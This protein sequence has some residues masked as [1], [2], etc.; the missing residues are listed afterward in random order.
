MLNSL[1]AGVSGIKNEQNHLDVISNNI[2]NANTTGFKSS[3]ITFA[4]ALSLNMYSATQGLNNSAGRNGMQIGAGSKVSSIDINFKQGNLE[5]TG[6]VRDMAIKGKGFFVVSDGIQNFYTRSGAFQLDNQGYLLAQGG[7]HNVMGKLADSEGNLPSTTS[8]SLEKIQIPYGAKSPA[9]ATSTIDFFCNLNKNASKTEEWMI[10]APWLTDSNA[11][12]GETDLKDIDGFIISDG[13]VIQLSGTNHDGS[14]VSSSFTYTE[15]TNTVED[16][17]TAIETAYNN[18]VTAE[19]DAYGK[20]RI[21]NVQAGESDFSITLTGI[22]N[23]PSQVVSSD[24]QYFTNSTGVATA[25]ASLNS[26]LQVT[27]DYVDGDT[28]D[29]TLNGATNTF[30]FGESNNGTTVQDLIDFINNSDFGGSSFTASIDDQGTLTINNASNQSQ[31]YSIAEGTTNTGSGLAVTVAGAAPINTAFNNLLQV[32]VAYEDGDVINVNINTQTRAFTYG[33]DGTTLQDLVNF[34]NSNTF[35]GET[36]TASLDADGNLNVV[37]AASATLA[38]ALTDGAANTGNGIGG[39]VSFTTTLPASYTQ[40][41]AGS[42]IADSATTLENVYGFTAGDFSI[43]GTSHN[44][45][46]FGPLTL[47]LTENQT[48]DEVI[49]EINTQLNGIGTASFENGKIVITDASA[50]VSQFDVTIENVTGTGLAQAFSVTTA[51]ADESPATAQVMQATGGYYLENTSNAVGTTAL[52]DLNEI[53]DY[54]NGDV[55]EIT[56]NDETLTFTYGTDGTTIEDVLNFINN[57]QFDGATFTASITDGVLSVVD[58]TT[59]AAAFTIADASTNTG[60]GFGANASYTITEQGSEVSSSSTTFAD[61]YGFTA[62]E[63]TISGNNH[64]GQ[65]IDSVTID[66]TEDMTIADLVARINSAFSGIATASFENGRIVLTDTTAGNSQLSINVA[67]ATGS[68]LAMNFAVNTLGADPTQSLIEI[69]PFTELTDGVQ[70]KHSTSIDV[71]DSQ[72]GRHKLEILYTQSTTTPNLWN[73][74]VMVDDGTISPVQGNKGTVEFNVDGSLKNMTYETGESLTFEVDGANMLDISLNMGTQGTLD[75]STQTASPSTN[76]AVNQDG[77][78][79]GVLNDINVNENGVITG[80][81]SNGISK[82]LAQVAIAN[83]NNEGGLEKLSGNMFNESA[84]S[85]SARIAYSGDSN[86][87]LIQSGYLENSN[88]DITEEFAR[89]IVAQRALQAN[90]KTINTADSVLSTIITQL[91]RS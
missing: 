63:F 75:G 71:Y 65:A 77:Y 67:D 73:W 4:D 5:A 84:T 42:A 52:N 74:E 14:S 58:D 60:S 64:N 76:I 44:G 59:A 30:T 15:E 39:Q 23:A 32:A 81:Y 9:K 50:G 51:G 33:T 34:I 31:V 38:Y 17:L 3:R 89:L 11:A 7:I 1:F 13:D 6:L 2:A 68:G 83:F 48:I 29:F 62:G 28:I 37:N 25:D 35:G 18:T 55:L 56:I 91:K 26:L 45:Q 43:S 24:N 85:G 86:S 8:G 78:T 36:V 53:I 57:N 88:V 72:G 12:N 79:L 82:T 19:I 22:G 61:V 69:K 40:N 49:A 80:I 10:S 21:R 27:T 66:I 46:S 20:I 16:L 41:V 70:G 47:S 87:T 90:A 54:V